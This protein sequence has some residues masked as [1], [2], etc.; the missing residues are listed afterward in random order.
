[1]STYDEKD[2]AFVKNT[3]TIDKEKND[4]LI[5]RKMG[6]LFT[7]YYDMKNV[8]L[9]LYETWKAEYF[10]LKLIRDEGE[11]RVAYLKKRLGRVGSLEKEN[12]GYRYYV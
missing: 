2:H 3:L 7:R 5:N 6:G 11:K 8:L 10:R 12:S 1:M 4:Y 9:V